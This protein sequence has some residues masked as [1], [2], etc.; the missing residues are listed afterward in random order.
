[1]R[2]KTQKTPPS[3]CYNCGEM[4][5][6]RDCPYRTKKCYDC[7]R[8]GHK[9]GSSRTFRSRQDQD[10]TPLKVPKRLRI[11]TRTLYKVRSKNPFEG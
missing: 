7:Q 1:M 10:Y 2:G 8:I 5:F 11:I 3:P 4:H 6:N 9:K